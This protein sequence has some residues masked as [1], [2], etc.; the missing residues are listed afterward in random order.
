MTAAW[1]ARSLEDRHESDVRCPISDVRRRGFCSAVKAPPPAQVRFAPVSSPDESPRLLEMNHS[2]TATVS[3]V[4][5]R[6]SDIRREPRPSSPSQ[7]LNGAIG[8]SDIE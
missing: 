1:R 2:K 3:E 5:R 8:M 4:R 7:K 6:T